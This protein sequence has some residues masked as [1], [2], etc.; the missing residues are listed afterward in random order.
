[1]GLGHEGTGGHLR[2]RCGAVAKARTSSLQKRRFP[3][4]QGRSHDSDGA[5]LAQGPSLRRPVVSLGL[6]HDPSRATVQFPALQVRQTG[7]QRSWDAPE[8]RGERSLRGR[9]PRAWGTVAPGPRAAGPE[10]EGASRPAPGGPPWEGTGSP[11]GRTVPVDLFTAGRLLHQVTNAC[12]G[13]QCDSPHIS[14]AAGEPQGKGAGPR[15]LGPGGCGTQLLTF[16]PV[17]VPSVPSLG[18]PEHATRERKRGD[19]FL[20]V[21]PV[22][23]PGL[24][25]G[26]ETLLSG[27]PDA[28][29]ERT[30][31][32]PSLRKSGAVGGLGTW[33][34][35]SSTSS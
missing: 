23:V 15:W 35:S 3:S 30:L 14:L 22:G 10:G 12:P 2:P 19:W 7:G 28:K 32:D 1:M 16:H 6:T 18:P 21:V 5:P 9:L 29:E 33:H 17:F 11:V 34:S 31:C 13:S 25:R 27:H 24:C 26:A 8:R 20:T 4:D